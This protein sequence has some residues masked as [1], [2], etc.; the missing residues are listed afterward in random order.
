VQHE[1]VRIP[2]KGTDRGLLCAPGPSPDVSVPRRAARRAR[3]L[4][5]FA[6]VALFGA[7][8]VLVLRDGGTLAHGAARLS[9]VRLAWIGLAVVAEA[10]SMVAF[11]RMQQKLLRAGGARLSLPS[12]IS[13]TTAA[14]AVT[15][16]LPGG[17]GW[18]AAWLY[19]HLASRQ[20][21]RF[22]RVW[23]FLVAGGVSSFALFCIIAAGVEIAGSRGP[24][25][26][27]RWL[28]F[29]LA[30]IPVVALLLDTFHTRPPVRHLV[31]WAERHADLRDRL[32]GLD[33]LRGIVS[34]FAAV[35]LGPGS[36]VSV[37]VLALENWLFDC[38]VA[39]VAMEALA[40]RVPWSGVLVVYGLTQ[41]SAAI[42]VTPGGIGVVEGSM[43]A[44]LHAYGVPVS[45]ALSVVLLYRIV[46]FWILVPIG[47]AAW[48]ALEMSVQTRQRREHR[49]TTEKP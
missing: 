13:I 42:P 48:G 20:V 47:W 40:V 10:G 23:M 12:M 36:W 25:A 44:L 1:R 21:A 5:A 24:V 49:P 9:H 11:G 39:I 8:V 43:T 22:V 17:G 3:H 32:R 30:L 27:L 26:S 28:V 41:I 38:A 33:R 16:T 18:A 4:R 6:S 37:L 29:L 31:E 19:D 2:D 14:N 46:S 34:H 45:S 7:A 15:A 35:R